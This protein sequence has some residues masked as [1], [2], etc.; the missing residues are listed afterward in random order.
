[1]THKKLTSTL[2]LA[3]MAAVLTLMVG[4]VQSGGRGVAHPRA[5]GK[6]EPPA[7]PAAVRDVLRTPLMPSAAAPEAPPP[8][9]A[10]VVAPAV[11]SSTKPRTARLIGTVWR[12]D[13]EPAPEARVVLGLQHARCDREGRFE[14]VLGDDPAG[15]DLI[16]F[17]PGYEPA[18]RPNFGS[19][20][21]RE[22][23]GEVRLTLGPP[24][25]SI[26]GTIVDRGGAPLKNWTVELDELD[27]LASFGLREHVRSDG[28]GRFLLTDVVT[29]VHVVRAWKERPEAVYRS[30]P[31]ESGA[32]SVTIVA[33]E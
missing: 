19:G 25:L 9:A 29:G 5:P 4:L 12:P 6:V 17:Q 13:G 27:P 30:L 26:S 18:L 31:V 10:P 20:L 1:M 21:T 7:S 8:V 24:T 11:E 22:H 33:D 15:A 2:V 3:A 28:D 16:A 32:T 23:D 14:L